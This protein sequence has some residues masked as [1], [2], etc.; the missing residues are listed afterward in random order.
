MVTT[1]D[2]KKIAMNKEPVGNQCGVSE[3]KIENAQLKIVWHLYKL[4][5]FCS[6]SF[7]SAP[8][9]SYKNKQV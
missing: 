1:D 3:N 9:E 4:N 8:C 5:S 7:R 2:M 6:F